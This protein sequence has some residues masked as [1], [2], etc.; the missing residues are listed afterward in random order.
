[1]VGLDWR[2]L[3]CQVTLIA[4]LLVFLEIDKPQSLSLCSLHH[5]TSV[6]SLNSVTT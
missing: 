4:V 6:T 5:V 1:M 2:S 3:I